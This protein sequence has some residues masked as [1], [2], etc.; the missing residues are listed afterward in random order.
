M[1]F[2]T[3]H[4]QIIVIA[5]FNWFAEKNLYLV[6]SVCLVTTDYSY[7][8]ICNATVDFTQRL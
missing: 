4:A 6:T 8:D 5:S 2:F 7:R 3:A 1:S